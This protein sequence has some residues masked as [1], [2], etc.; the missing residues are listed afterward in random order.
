MP[1]EG[2]RRHVSA[3][4]ARGAPCACPATAPELLPS[5]V[6]RKGNLPRTNGGHAPGHGTWTRSADGP[7]DRGRS[8][9]SPRERRARCRPVGQGTGAMRPRLPLRGRD[10]AL[11]RRGSAP[12]TTPPN[13]PPRRHP[14]SVS[15][16]PVMLDPIMPVQPRV[17][18]IVPTY[19][20]AADLPPLMEALLHQHVP[21]GEFEIIVVNNASTDETAAVLHA[22][23]A[24]DHRVRYVEEGRRGAAYAR[25]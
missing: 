10:T 4:D 9:L 23:Q 14:R 8:S 7:D 25:N 1:G 17:S 15:W 6:V 12:G 3:R 11:L 5:L 20:R 19:N 21:D 13:P 16:L 24:R 2:R 18:V 22:C